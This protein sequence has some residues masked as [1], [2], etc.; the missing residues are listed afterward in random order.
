MSK[1]KSIG[2]AKFRTK[3]LVLLF[4]AIIACAAFAAY[5][6]ELK[7][8]KDYMK[9][10]EALKSDDYKA[11][12]QLYASLG[13]Y[14]DSKTQYNY[15]SCMHLFTTG[16]VTEAAKFYT[17]L[18]TASQK[19]VEEKMGSF[20]DL[21]LAA[22]TGKQYDNARAFLSIS[23]SDED[24]SDALK[25]L[26]VRAEAAE[27]IQ[28]GEYRSAREKLAGYDNTYINATELIEDSYSLEF[29]TYDEALLNTENTDIAKAAEGLES[30]AFEYA[31]A[32]KKLRQITEAYDQAMLCY[33][34][35]DYEGAVAY[36]SGLGNYRDSEKM[37]EKCNKVLSGEAINTNEPGD[38]I[39]FGLMG[40]KPL[41]WVVVSVNDTSMTLFSQVPVAEMAFSDEANSVNAAQWLETEFMDS[42]TAD[43]KAKISKITYNS[44]N[45]M[46]TASVHIISPMELQQIVPE[47]YSGYDIVWTSCAGANESTAVAF[48]MSDTTATFELEAS[49]I[50]SVMAVIQVKY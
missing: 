49:E 38:I 41:K 4:V 22:L 31:P 10:E 23:A 1:Q 46:G 30:I 9:A 12:S 47:L 3:L 27:L 24:T 5:K 45:G 26:D 20:K 25:A 43:E 15:S 35:G 33:K 14:K 21:G 36:F 40:D 42:F 28:K 48:N 37:I 8:R 19:L 44:G 7:P 16:N 13:G 39:S 17:G 32:A 34:G 29:K 50:H 6:Y 2:H 18:D 11:A